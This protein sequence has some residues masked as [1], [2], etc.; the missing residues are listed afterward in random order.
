MTTPYCETLG[1]DVPS[2][3]HVKDHKEARTY[4][5]LI[6]ALLEHGRAMTLAEV[7]KRFDEAGVAPA[8]DALLSLKRCRPARAP[9]YR[10]G[11]D[12]GLDP[13]DDEL[14]FW[15][16][17]LGLRPPRATGLRIVP[18]PLAGVELPL[19]VAELDEA[20]RDQDLNGWSAQRLALAILEAHGRAMTPQAVVAFADEYDQLNKLDT[21]SSQ[22]WR[23]DAA[24]DVR[25]DGL[26][27]LRPGSGALISARRAVRN[28]IEVVRRLAAKRPD[29]VVLDVNRRA[30]D[31]RRAACA[32]ELAGLR[33]VLVHAFPAKEPEAVVLLDVGAHE[34]T[35]FLGDDLER[36][37]EQLAAYDLIGAVDVRALMRALGFDVGE[38]RLSELGPPQKSVSLNKRG[39]TLKLTTAMFIQGSCGIGRPLG[40]AKKLREYLREGRTTRLIRRLEADVKSLYA[41]YEYGR[42]HGAVRLRWGFLDEMI[43]VPW[44]HHDEQRLYH[45]MDRAHAEDRSLEVV[46]GTAP[47]WSEPWAR[48]QRCRAEQDLHGYGLQLVDEDGFVVER[49]EVQR[50]RLIDP[51]AR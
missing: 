24:I 34:L 16:F 10:D 2:L 45:L 28:R 6:V 31:R 37:R 36:A 38:R 22:Y 8:E 12:Y 14:E 1:I 49:H 46:V 23:R 30:A 19:T 51:T 35:T 11:D 40:D 47:G 17:R 50:A 44:G 9:V 15:T 48:A 29:P 33:R 32:A 39:R 18:A 42:L 13:H 7:A 3:E 25:E 21:D 27:E 4:S 41:L 5:L 43:S 20:W 26:W